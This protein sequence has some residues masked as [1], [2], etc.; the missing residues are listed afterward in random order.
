M[1]DS[2]TPSIRRQLEQ[3]Q[4]KQ[5]KWQVIPSA[6]M[7]VEVRKRDEAFGVNL[8]ERSCDCRLWQLTGV[9]CVH[10]VAAYL[11][12]K[13]EPDVGVSSWYSQS[14][15]FDTYQFSIKPV[16]GSKFWKPTNNTPPVPPI[17]KRMPGRPRKVRI[18]HP[19]E[20]LN[21]NKVSR[22][23]RVITCTKCWQTGH[24][25]VSCSNTPREKPFTMSQN[26]RGETS[27]RGGGSL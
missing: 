16:S 8:M 7:V 4:L 20:T 22:V 9:P 10:A 14:K 11:T 12:Q 19:T 5:M 18:K 6:Y 27:K 2:I 21:E 15:W 25:R 1:S 24:N 23:G 13:M 3:L 26:K 17:V